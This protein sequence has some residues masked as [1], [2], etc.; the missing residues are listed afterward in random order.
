[1]QLGKKLVNT[2]F[3]SKL[4]TTALAVALL[5]G[6][7]ATL[8][9]NLVQ[10]ATL[11]ASYL[12]LAP[13]SDATQ[14]NFSWHT[15][16][17][18]NNDAP[19]VRI[20]K[21]GGE[22]MEFTGV[23]SNSTSTLSGQYYNRV[24][25]TDLEA[26]TTY[27]Y[28]LGNGYGDWSVEYTTTTGD[29]T[30]FSY[31]VF[32]DPQVSSQ[33][34]GNNWKNTLE[35]ALALRPDLAF[36]SSTGDQID[37]ATKAQYDYFFTPQDIFNSLP[38]ASCIGNHE[39]NTTSPLF[40][41]PPNADSQGNYWYT[42]GDVLFMVWNSTNGNA[43]DLRNFLTSA[44]TANPDTNWT[45]LNF[46]Y[47]VYGQGSSH[48]LS[49]GKSYRDTYVPVIDQFNID[50]V[51]NGHDH[52]YSRSFPMKW[53]GSASTS[54]SQGMQPQVQNSDGSYTIPDG[55]T[56]YFSLS[57]SSGQKYYSAAAKQ[58][59]TAFMPASQ[60]NRPHFS[61]VDM[62]AT[63]FTCTTYQVETNNTLTI[64]DTYTIVKP[65]AEVNPELVITTD[66]KAVRDGQYFNVKASF[67]EKVNSN[68]AIVSFL[69][70]TTLFD[71]RDFT[72]AA[73]VTVL[74]VSDEDG[75]VSFTVMIDGYNTTDYGQALFSVKDDVK[76]QKGT[77]TITA[78]ADLV[79]LSDDGKRII[80]FS[81]STTIGTLPVLSK[82]TL[83]DLSNAIDAFGFNTSTFGWDDIYYLFDVDFDGEITI[84]DIT[85]IA[86]MVALD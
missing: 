44:I 40:F 14:L 1:M 48:A 78:K 39:S 37:S 34:Y 16:S 82:F 74:D 69:Y 27:T 47:D 57:S 18:A 10:A 25:A 17:R 41:N 56:V 3:I 28:Q 2:K 8:L 50:V 49:D 58:A 83:I 6:A 5:F 81:A 13:G 30:S 38:L 54:N 65:T 70:D 60:S 79:L 24:T 67:S 72:P 76:L 77:S 19:V 75:M 26:N 35:L 43:N 20:C 29:S 51:F 86:K 46:H 55:G 42:Y 52:F 64:V 84:N 31:L 23:G 71:Y 73:G 4:L 61:I 59:Y 45:I 33:T 68:A 15:A 85:I 36:M 7:N 66:I 21:V 22:T 9:P 80:T 53:S 11:D 62:T 12:T 63:S 32:G